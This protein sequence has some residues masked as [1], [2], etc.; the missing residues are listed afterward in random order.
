[1]ICRVVSTIP[2]KPSSFVSI[3]TREQTIITDPLGVY[4]K[5]RGGKYN[6]YL[7]VDLEVQDL[8]GRVLALD[9]FVDLECDLRIVMENGDFGGVLD[10][11]SKSSNRLMTKHLEGNSGKLVVI[12]ADPSGSGI[13]IGGPSRSSV[14]IRINELRLVACM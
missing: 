11:V 1:M 8:R 10:T 14:K 4:Q 12:D 13:R 7:I 2:S 6:N 3:V 5:D 9:Y